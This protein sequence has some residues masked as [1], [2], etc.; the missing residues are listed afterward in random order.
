M[1]K[2]D[3][4]ELVKPKRLY[5]HKKKNQSGIYI[6]DSFETEKL[7][8]GSSV[9]LS[10]RTW[11]DHYHALNNNRHVNKFLQNHANK[12]GIKDLAFYIVGICEK[13]QLNEL[14][15][16]YL[17]NIDKEIQFN[18]ETVAGNP[19]IGKSNPMNNPESRRKLSEAH[20]GKVISEKSRM[21]MSKAQKGKKLTQKQKQALSQ[22]NKKGS[23]NP[24]YGKKMTEKQK[25]KM[26]EAH[27]GKKLPKQTRRRMSES[28]KGE[29]HPMY[30]KNHSE[31]TKQVL[32]D[33]NEGK[34]LSPETRRKM[35]EG[36]KR[37]HARNKNNP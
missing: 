15:Q 11:D 32:S 19:M 1:N 30:G 35:S 28:R 7:Y 8:I 12:Y 37:R 22:N 29:N 23:D 6:I 16:W 10:K 21:R 33:Q 2:N 20:L 9:D 13:D 26:S 17:N 4:F 25:Q 18:I 36:Q 31:E 24:S 5:K 3:L 27:K 14:E 34:R